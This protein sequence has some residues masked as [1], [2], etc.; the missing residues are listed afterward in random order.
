MHCVSCYNN[1][2]VAELNS[3]LDSPPEESSGDWIDTST[4]LI[5]KLDARPTDECVANAKLTLVATRELTSLA[6]DVLCELH[7]LKKIV[8]RVIKLLTGETFHP[9]E[10]VE[11]LFRREILPEAVK[12][13]T[14]TKI[15]EELGT[16]ATHFCP[17]EVGGSVGLGDERCEE[18]EKSGF[19]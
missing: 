1:S 14:D 5:E 16:V 6:I 2:A 19:A 9:P 3:L 10:E 15:L 11:V 7:G 13:R 8:D 12:L 4:R 17:L 18:T